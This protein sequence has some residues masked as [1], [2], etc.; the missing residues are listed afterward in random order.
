[1]LN[2]VRVMLESS[3]SGKNFFK[4]TQNNRDSRLSRLLVEMGSI[5]EVD[6]HIALVTAAIV[7]SR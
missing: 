6:L 5:R 4:G 2:L 3:E 1:M 7:C